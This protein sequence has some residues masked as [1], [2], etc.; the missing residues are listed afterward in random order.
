MRARAPAWLAWSLWTLTVMLVALGLLLFWAASGRVH[1]PFSVY[2]P[3]LCVSALSLST[4]GALI[5]SRREE[6]PIGWLFCASGLLFGVQVLAGEYGLY[7]LFVSRGSLPAGVVSWWLSSWVWVPATQLVL[8][9]FLLF[10]DGRLPSPRWRIVAWLLV[11]GILLDV[12]SFALVPGPLL[13]SGARGLAPVQNPFGSESVVRFLDS[14]GI[15]LNPLLAVLVLAPVA[16]LLVRFRRSAG[17]ER[18]QIK[19]VLYA[20]AALTVAIT[21][22]SIWPALDGSRIGQV[23]FLAGFL[24]IPTAVGIAILR[25]RLYD[26]D[27]LINRTLVYGVLTVLLAALYFEG[28]IVLQYALR[29]TT[30]QE[31]SLAVVASTLAIAA[32]FN[33]LR[34]RVQSFVDRRFYRRK[35]DAER[36]LADFSTTLR[37]GT[38]LGKLDG[39]LISTIRE[40]VQPEHASLWLREP[41]RRTQQTGQQNADA[42]RARRREAGPIP[43]PPEESPQIGGP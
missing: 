27:V 29:A 11:G 26:I 2:L 14:V 10:P 6:N 39:D 23:L 43:T 17:E 40:T 21:V 7:A 35:Y 15:V 28:V 25:H 36:V 34:R 4:F 18:Q 42:A 5:A 12:A 41:G 32:L 3:N 13:E 20:V 24:A 16:A 37:Y 8:F 38:D 22:V 1:D 30:G 19:W 9:L 31:S 33:P